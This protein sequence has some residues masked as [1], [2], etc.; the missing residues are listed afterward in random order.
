MEM[1]GRDYRELLRGEL[2]LRQNKNRTYSLRAFAKALKV[3]PTT[4]SMVLQN[5][6]S[7]SESSIQNI[8]QALQLDPEESRVFRAMVLSID[9]DTPEVRL[10]YS[11]ELDSYHSNRK[12]NDKYYDLSVSAFRVIA[13]WYHLAILELLETK[14][15][16]AVTKDD[17]I[18]W[19]AEKF[20][21]GTIQ[22]KVAF[23][24]LEKL[25]LIEYRSGKPYKTD[26]ILHTGDKVPSEAIRSHHRQYLEKAIQA[27]QEQS[28]DECDFSGIIVPVDSEK[29]P[30]AKKMIQ[31]FRKKMNTF[32][33]GKNNSDVYRLS[34]SF[35]RI[36]NRSK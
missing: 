5:K 14:D 7:L 25:E 33:R 1:H 4:L 23:D 34:V 17:V 13:D 32:L 9:G 2:V 15:Y 27:I 11:Q 36:S 26:G 24:H 21:I 12:Q 28:H 16:Q 30:E 3:N 22:V 18:K 6:R 10:R 31:E 19:I 29:L 35:F 20:G 8:I